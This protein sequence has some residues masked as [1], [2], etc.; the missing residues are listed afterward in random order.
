MFHSLFSQVSSLT[1]RLMQTKHTFF[2]MIEKYKEQSKY[3]N[4]K[5][6]RHV[7]RQSIRTQQIENDLIYQQDDKNKK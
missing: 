1:I 7:R 3:Y 6:I 2:K 5:T 4:L